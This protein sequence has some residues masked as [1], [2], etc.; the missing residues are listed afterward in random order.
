MEE[1]LTQGADC[2]ADQ[3]KAGLD[4]ALRFAPHL[5]HAY[6]RLLAT[7]FV[8]RPTTLGRNVLAWPLPGICVMVCAKPHAPSTAAEAAAQ[9]RGDA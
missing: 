9:P 6:E 7:G 5:R 1:S 4:A 3:A 8:P 2:R